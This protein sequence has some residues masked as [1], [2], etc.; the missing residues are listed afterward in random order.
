[1]VA[2]T[3]NPNTGEVETVDP[4]VYWPASLAY[5]ASKP[6]ANVR[7]C[8]NQ[9]KP[10]QTQTKTETRERWLSIKSACCFYRGFEFAAEQ[11]RSGS[12]LPP[13]TLALG[14]F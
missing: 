3:Y 12:S 11:L 7:P 10:N 4:V 1:M 8:H 6:Q 5:L 14:I 9:T 13:L 2:Y